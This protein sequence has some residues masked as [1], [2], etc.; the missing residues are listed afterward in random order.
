MVSV[1]FNVTEETKMAGLV[2]M[3][4][5]VAVRKS[6]IFRQVMIG[7]GDLQAIELFQI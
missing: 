7:F 2:R 4:S 6:D 3:P 5:K 1:T